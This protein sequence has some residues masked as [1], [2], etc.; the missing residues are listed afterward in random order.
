MKKNLIR[1]LLLAVALVTVFALAS[2]SILADFGINIPGMGDTNEDNGGGNDGG[3]NEEPPVEKEGELLLI[4]NGKA[5]FNVVYTHS[6]GASGKRA[7]DDFV[8]ELRNIEVKVNDAV[9]DRD[10]SKVTECEIIIGADA[11]NRGD[12]CCVTTNYLGK[13][14]QVI[15]I[16]GKRIIIAGGTPDLTKKTFDIYVRNQ[17]NISSKTDTIDTLYVK[18]DYSYTKLTE[19]GIESIKI[20]D[21]DLGEFTLVYDIAAVSKDN[22]PVMEIKTFASSIF[23]KSGIVVNAGEFSKLDTY[24]HAIIIRY[25]DT[26]VGFARDKSHE[27]EVNGGFRA[28]IDGD[29]YIIECCYKNAFEESYIDFM[30]EVFLSKRG[31]IVV[32][33]DYTDDADTVYYEDFGAKGNGSTDDF[34]AMYKT[35]AYANECGQTVCGKPGSHYYVG[36]GSLNRT[37]PVTTDVNFNGATIT[38]NDVGSAAYAHR[39]NKLFTTTRQHQVV[40]LTGEEVY[41]LYAEYHKANPDSP[42]NLVIGID[43]E[44]FPWLAS[45]LEADSMVRILSSTHKDFVRHGANENSGSN[46]MDVF[47]VYANGDFVRETDKDLDGNGFIGNVTTPVA[48]TFGSTDVVNDPSVTNDK[49]NSAITQLIIYRNDDTPITI[50]NGNFY[51]ICCQAVAETDFK[52][53]YSAHY[54]GFELYRSNVTIK[55]IKHRMKDEP[56]LGLGHSGHNGYSQQG[57]EC[58]DKCASYGSRKESYPYYGFFFIQFTSNLLIQDC[59]LTG[60]TVYYEDKPATGST[61]GQIPNPVPAGSYDYVVERSCSVT[62]DNVTQGFSEDK[63]RPG[64]E[65]GTVERDLGDNRYWGIMSSNGSKNMT[66]KDCKI[67]RFDAH[68]GFWNATLINTEIGHSFNVVGGGT[69]N[70]IGV[71]KHTGNNGFI[72]LRGDYGATFRGHMNLID[73][74]YL[75]YESFNSNKGGVNS[76]IPNASGTIIQ[77]GFAT[78]NNGYR[79]P[80]DRQKS[81][82]AQYAETYADEMEKYADK[83]AAGTMTKEQAQTNA[84][85][86]A[87]TAATKM[88][89]QGGYW[90]WDF[91]YD[92]Y[93][94]ITIN[95]KNFQSPGTQNLYMFPAFTDKI[96][97]YNYDPNNETSDSV[98]NVYN[99]TQAIN[100]AEASAAD[101]PIQIKICSAAADNANYSKLYSIPVTYG[102]EWNNPFEN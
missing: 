23:D 44:S 39:N 63:D 12:D 54:R 84:A 93:L 100:I 18:D 9:S 62:F 37:I 101:M 65:I 51:N 52:V 87:T 38:V 14:G 74:T 64:Q 56:E 96:F 70:A 30:D 5:L 1:I 99:I 3:E 2:C 40:Y 78:T 97:T 36:P 4:H 10:A 45:K 35:H 79:T 55:N 83:I 42:E 66:F 29:N 32:T 20:G 94:P 59:N 81:Y 76:F 31:K 89:K 49:V 91:G 17:M 61:G 102:Y 82:D 57:P 60:H 48:Y 8:K 67:N 53:K 98:T 21:T 6:S 68:Q 26:Y 75:N 28:Y 16:V 77:A 69:L 24:E 58:D 86:T 15:K 92:C 43:T 73:C 72:A 50:E 34:E 11:A 88:A 33:E 85:A 13:D 95:I 90:L 27:L 47:M 22:F 71:T 41:A 46:R 7:A 25:V 80:E 19:Y